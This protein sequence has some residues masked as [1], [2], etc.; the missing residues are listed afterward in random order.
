MGFI[1]NLRG[2]F[3][4]GKSAPSVRHLIKVHEA[5][6]SEYAK[7]KRL[8]D[9]QILRIA[10]DTR[11]QMKDIAFNLAGPVVNTSADF[12]AGQPIVF[13]VKDAE[14]NGNE[15]ATRI[16]GEIWAR[17][18]AESKFLPAAIRAGIYGDCPVIIRRDEAN[19]V[20]LDFPSPDIVYPTFDPHDVDRIT[21]AIVAYSV[22]NE[23]GD[24][25]GYYEDFSAGTITRTVGDQSETFSYDPSKFDGGVPVLWI[26]NLCI[27]ELFGR[28]DLTPLKRL[29]ERY[30]HISEKEL[31]IVDY[32]SSPNVVA[33]GPTIQELTGN[34]IPFGFRRLFAIKETHDIEYLEWKGD[35]PDVEKSIEHV[36]QAIAEISEVP[37]IAFGKVPTGLSQVSG[38]ALKILY[39][40]LLAKTRR[41]RASYG[42]ILERAMLFALREDGQV[43]PEEQSVSIA[44]T[45]PTP[46]NEVE[47]WQ[48]ANEK[49]GAG[50]SIAQTLREAGYDDSEIVKIQAEKEAETQLAAANAASAFN[51]G[52]VSDPNNPALP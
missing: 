29:L 45:D 30:D 11:E 27:G 32:Y 12:L 18:G 2:L 41:K 10:T 7:Y 17:S 52:N 16:A 25:E 46:V 47:K 15:G 14:G 6:F 26:R 33:K 36:R 50:V 40:P 21:R 48:T 8:Y 44:W 42:P 38:V 43:I 31:D 4:K 22:I 5:R 51:A 9:G 49:E 34:S 3:G 13:T 24:Q 23:N 37:S 28:S 20:Y 35:R 19:K 39:G 1:D